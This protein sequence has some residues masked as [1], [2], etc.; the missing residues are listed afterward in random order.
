MVA[1]NSPIPTRL[2]ATNCQLITSRVTRIAAVLLIVQIAGC[3]IVKF[4]K[5]EFGRDQARKAISDS[6]A[7]R[8]GKDWEATRCSHSSLL[9]KKPEFSL[10]HK[11]PICMAR[12]EVTGIRAIN[13]TERVVDWD[14]VYTFDRE[15]LQAH[16]ASL[17]KLEERL[18]SLPGNTQNNGFL[19]LTT[20]VDPSD[21]EVYSPMGSPYPNQA[22]DKSP[23]FRDY[24]KMREWFASTIEK[25]KMVDNNQTIF[26]L[27][28]DGWRIKK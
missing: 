12:V 14:T 2:K 20:Y 16:L 4:G 28:D 10:I 9:A 26:I 21:G 24:Q 13:D 11:R 3:G 15:L 19:F 1:R 18:R 5:P 8:R 22:I 6:I 23:Q 17:D 27:Y 25:G 7:K